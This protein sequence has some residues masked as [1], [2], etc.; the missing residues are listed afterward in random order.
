LIE[1]GLLI[2]CSMMC[3]AIAF[4]RRRVLPSRFGEQLAGDQGLDVAFTLSAFVSYFVSVGLAIWALFK[5]EPWMVLAN[6][7]AGQYLG[8]IIGRILSAKVWQSG[9]TVYW[10]R[11][12]VYVF[13][14][15]VGVAGGILGCR[16][17]NA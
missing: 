17:Q 15:V 8:G 13:L 5:L 7:L 2:L 9:A 6:F 1:F 12:A 4:T 3:E 11:S 16:L 14:C 10:V